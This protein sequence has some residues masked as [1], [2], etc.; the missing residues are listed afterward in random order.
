ML[1]WKHHNE[2]PDMSVVVSK[3]EQIVWPSFFAS[4]HCFI[5]LFLLQGKKPIEKGNTVRD[6]ETKACCLCC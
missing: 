3:I 4:L 1:C 6:E 2:R 5:A